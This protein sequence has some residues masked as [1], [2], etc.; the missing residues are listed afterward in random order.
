MKRLTRLLGAVA[1]LACGAGV[2]ARAPAGPVALTVTLP[3][4]GQKLLYVEESMP[5]KPGPV[6]LYYPKWIP[7]DHSP[8]GEI[9]KV[10]GLEFTAAGKRVAWHR[11]ELDKFTFLLTIPEGA[12][13]LD[14]RFQFPARDRITANLLDLTWDSVAFYQA[15]SPTKL[16]TYEPTIVI[17]ADWQYA[18]ALE[19]AK[20]DGTT[21]TF[22]PVPF[23][24]LVDSP[25]IAG[26][27]FRTIDVTPPGASVRRFLDMVGDSEAA[28]NISDKQIAGYRNL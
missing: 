5:V 13:R 24:T 18:S 2:N 28:I 20:H 9:E 23:N 22:K 19:T 10:L 11:D 17:P 3:D 15:G 1:F 16:Q 21:V 14:I 7:G 12:D 6:T 25:V 4:P 26:K 27:Y 8:D